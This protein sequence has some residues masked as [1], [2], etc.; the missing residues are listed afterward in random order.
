[1]EMRIALDTNR[2]SDLARGAIDI[3]EIVER[4]T[5]VFLPFAVV[6]E[7]RG[8]FLRGGSMQDNERQLQDFFREH[9][10]QILYP[11]EATTR[12]YGTLYA[13]LRR[14]GTP[15]PTNDIWIAALVVQHGLTLCTRDKHFDHLP[16]LA[17]L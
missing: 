7:L 9:T 11:D 10:A 1:M 17:R 4:A 2:Y 15:I 12:H 16:Q 5:E 8:G 6:G 13:Q 3:R 14:Q